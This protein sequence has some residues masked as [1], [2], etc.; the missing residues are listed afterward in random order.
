MLIAFCC[1]TAGHHSDAVN[2]DRKKSEENPTAGT[3]SKLCAIC[4]L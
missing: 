4:T 2:E 3:W 1:H